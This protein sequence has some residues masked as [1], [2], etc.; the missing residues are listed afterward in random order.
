MSIIAGSNVET[1]TMNIGYV[2]TNLA[3][4]RDDMAKPL[5]IP[6]SKI[7]LFLSSR[8]AIDNFFLSYYAS[9]NLIDSKLQF[10]F[11]TVSF[12]VLMIQPWNRRQVNLCF[13]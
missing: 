12:V 10:C 4:F 9:L 8:A 1:S 7:I 13:I 3:N 5:E 6:T 11:N 2:A